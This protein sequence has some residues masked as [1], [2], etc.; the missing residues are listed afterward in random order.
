MEHDIFKVMDNY[1]PLSHEEL[2]TQPVEK[3][4][5]H[6]LRFA[7]TK[8]MEMSHKYPGLS[9]D[10]IIEG[11]LLGATEAAN[12]WDPSKSKITSYMSFWIRAYIKGI[13]NENQHAVGRNTMYIWK[14][15]KI[16]SFVDEFKS[17]NNREPTIDEISAG[18]EFSKNT[19]YNIHNLGIKSVSSIDGSQSDDTDGDNNLNDVISDTSSKTPLEEASESDI[20][21]IMERLIDGLDDLEKEV[22]TRRWYNNHKYNQIAAD[23]N[24]AYPKIK[25]AETRALDKL[26]YELNLIE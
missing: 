14:A 6:N 3:I 10:E 4:I 8:A 22:I 17:I 9:N 26:K 18:T 5:L 19:V 12:R 15:H 7:Y 24:V 13:A 16:A 11:M 2:I 23:L 25:Q 1:A 21:S 20:Y